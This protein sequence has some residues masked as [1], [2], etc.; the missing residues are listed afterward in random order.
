MC[1]I[2]MRHVISAYLPGRAEA[3]DSYLLVVL[4]VH[5]PNLYA[6]RHLYL[7]TWPRGGTPPPVT[8]HASTTGALPG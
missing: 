7:P 2:C 5:V 3:L 8:P 4:V 6:P 1:P